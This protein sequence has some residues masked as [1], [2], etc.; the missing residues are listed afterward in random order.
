MGSATGE[1]GWLGSP[2]CSPRLDME[3]ERISC[4][5][6]QRRNHV[7]SSL[8]A[9]AYNEAGLDALERINSLSGTAVAVQTDQGV[10]LRSDVVA[11]SRSSGIDSSCRAG[12]LRCSAVDTCRRVAFS[13]RS[14]KRCLV[15]SPGTNTEQQFGCTR[16]KR[17]VLV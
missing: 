1:Y 4:P 16:L 12:P 6:W 17:D 2:L 7:C 11:R 14:W 10:R 13:R 15:E 8:H 5:N 9:Y 3:Q